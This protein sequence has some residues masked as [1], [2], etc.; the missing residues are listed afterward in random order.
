MRFLRHAVAVHN[1]GHPRRIGDAV[2]T[3]LVTHDAWD[4][5][6]RQQTVK[7]DFWEVDGGCLIFYEYVQTIIRW[8]PHVVAA[9]GLGQWGHVCGMEE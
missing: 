9:Y 4:D 6:S 7:A 3:F 5:G 8:D 1:I 2:S